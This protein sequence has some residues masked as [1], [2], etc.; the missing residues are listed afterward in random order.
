MQ[1]ET[2]IYFG[3]ST[4]VVV[5][6]GVVFRNS[7]PL[8]GD[9]LA[10]Y[11]YFFF[12]ANHIAVYGDLAF[13]NPYLYIGQKISSGFLFHFITS[14]DF[15]LTLL[16]SKIK[17]PLSFA[18][19]FTISRSFEWLLTY[20]VCYL[21]GR[22]WKLNTI[23]SF[24]LGT[25][26]CI[27]YSPISQIW[28]TNIVIQ[29]LWVIYFIFRYQKDET[30]ANA[31]FMTL[32]VLY[33]FFS[34]KIVGLMMCLSPLI[35]LLI[36]P[37]TVRIFRRPKILIPCV[38]IFIVFIV[39]AWLVVKANSNYYH[40]ANRS[41]GN[42]LSFKGD[43]ADEYIVK[44]Q[45]GLNSDGFDMRGVLVSR[46]WTKLSTKIERANLYM[47]QDIGG[48]GGIALH[49]LAIL[50]MFVARIPQRR[51]LLAC[52]MVMFVLARFP[53]ILVKL[54]LPDIVVFLFNVRYFPFIFGTLKCFTV[55][56]AALGV[57][58]LIRG[59][60]LSL[61]E[62]VGISILSAA[63]IYAGTANFLLVFSVLLFP[64]LHMFSTITEENRAKVL[65]SLLILIC[66]GELIKIQYQLT[67]MKRNP[68]IVASPQDRFKDYRFKLL[69]FRSRREANPIQPKYSFQNASHQLDTPLPILSGGK[70]AGIWAGTI[71]NCYYTLLNESTPD[72]VNQ[73]NGI[74]Q[75]IISFLPNKSILSTDGNEQ[76]AN[77]QK[78][79]LR[80]QGGGAVLPLLQYDV[81]RYDANQFELSVKTAE[82]GTLRLSVL[83]DPDWSTWVDGAKVPVGTVDHCLQAIPLDSGHHYVKQ[84]YNSELLQS[85]AFL[86]AF[87]SLFVFTLRIGCVIQAAVQNRK[88]NNE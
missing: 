22:H 49:V 2:K 35:V 1:I 58:H 31:I 6:F 61:W 16:L 51:R 63:I 4:L 81:V 55:I 18:I 70:Q 33:L 53:I 74:N 50:G 59:G 25:A 14:P 29:F 76:G 68:D 38:L 45:K 87:T 39:P 10:E 11:D 77:L 43:V 88:L 24:F 8:T 85:L 37:T 47:V 5:F 69:N 44:T 21:L 79:P 27:S 3:L 26:I 15:W 12:Q 73:L 41:T 42:Y 78:V 9:A 72:E 62:N 86:L 19:I 75:D 52:M 80:T 71:A 13:W 28:P 60:K 54:P 84:E 67:S 32:S 46:D 7:I 30:L 57:H 48:Y 56:F 17:N 40:Y 83:S 23:A 20:A 82:P 66:V 36:H 64:A 65:A 34:T